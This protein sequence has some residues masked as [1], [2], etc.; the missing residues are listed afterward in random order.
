MPAFAITAGV[1]AVFQ[2]GTNIYIAHVFLSQEL[3]SFGGGH[4]PYLPDERITGFGLLFGRA[5]AFS[6]SRPLFPLFPI[7]WLLSSK[8]T[9]YRA[10]AAIGLSLNRSILREGPIR[11]YTTEGV[12]Q[13]TH[14][15]IARTGIGLPIQIE[16]TQKLTRSI[17]YVH[18]AYVNIDQARTFW[19]VSWAIQYSW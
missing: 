15:P 12:L 6:L 2:S 14:D 5:H 3:N 4:G 19:T 10:T 8:E 16:L 13:S 1:E 9:E 18:R 7:P 17:G 11:Y